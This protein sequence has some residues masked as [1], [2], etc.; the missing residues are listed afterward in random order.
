MTREKLI[1]GDIR[2][3]NIW[4]KDEVWKI[5]DL[6]FGKKMAAVDPVKSTFLKSMRYCYSTS[7]EVFFK[8]VYNDRSDIWS[9]GILLYLLVYKRYPWGGNDVFQ[10]FQNIQQFAAYIPHTPKIS[11]F[12]KDLL[13]VLLK[14]DPSQRLPIHKVIAH[15]IFK[16]M[17]D[18]EQRKKDAV[19]KEQQGSK[20]WALA[21]EIL[22]GN[23]TKKTKDIYM[24][25]L[26]S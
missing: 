7:P 21:T 14:R 18:E 5:A 4:L 1:H 8:N 23:T 13:Q 19:L 24:S 16:F 25:Q 11:V 15:P 22:F 6:G 10:Y 26:R 20:D 2:L 17:R 12:T 3:E 9:L